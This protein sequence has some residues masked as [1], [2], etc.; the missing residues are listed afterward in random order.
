MSVKR[1]CLLIIV[2]SSLAFILMLGRGT[3]SASD[4]ETELFNKGYEY[5][6]SYKPD[7]AAEIFRLFLEEF[8]D[9]SAR[10]AAM[11][12]LGKTLIS[13]KSYSEAELMFQTIQKE[14]PD[15]PFIVFIVLEMKELAK[16]RSTIEEE[17]KKTAELKS[18]QASIREEQDRPQ[19]LRDTPS[20]PQ[21]D[22]NAVV[23]IGSRDY[24]LARII[25]YHVSASLVFKRFGIKDIAW[26]TG[27]PLDDFIS[28]ELLFLEAKKANITIDA[29][30]QKEIAESQKLSA[31]E[32]DYIEKFMTIA[33]YI[34][35]Q[36]IDVPPQHRVETLSVDY[37][38]GDA[39]SKTV[40][41]TDL[42]KAA[43]EGISFEEIARTYPDRV[44]FSS[45]TPQDFSTKY[46]EKSQLLQKL[47][48]LNEETVVIWSDKGYMLIKPITDRVHFNPFEELSTQK[49][50][51]LKAFLKQ[52][53]AEHRK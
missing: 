14:F 26:R 44:R 15:S 3:A 24:P 50:E 6:F 7:K 35:T 17:R 1:F 32:K 5:L 27:N 8:P 45:L 11:F 42:Q 53:L 19:I 2:I 52:W 18:Q 48:F 43:R 49:K 9:S 28:E 39:A 37:R 41:A 38:P 36:Y 33:G 4:R 16:Q 12:W 29:K 46:K 40:L 30:K 21:L 31:A 34:D 51:K 10:D 25:D 47:N 20:A 13:T 22:P 23:R